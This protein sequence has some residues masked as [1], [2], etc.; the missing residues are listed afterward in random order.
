MIWEKCWPTYHV[1]TVCVG[2]KELVSSHHI[3]FTLQTVEP[4]RSGEAGDCYLPG[5]DVHLS[6]LTPAREEKQPEK[7]VMRRR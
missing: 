2:E 6:H 4:E 1:I 7:E 3:S 5:E